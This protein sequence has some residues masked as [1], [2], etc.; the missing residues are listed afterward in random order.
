MHFHGT[1]AR[2]RLSRRDGAL[3]LFF[4]IGLEHEGGVIGVAA[5]HPRARAA[6]RD[7]LRRL[8]IAEVLRCKEGARRRHGVRTGRGARVC[9]AG[10]G[11]ADGRPRVERQDRAQQRRMLQ[12]IADRVRAAHRSAGAAHSAVWGWFAAR[13]RQARGTAGAERAS[14]QQQ[15]GGR[16]GEAQANCKLTGGGSAWSLSITDQVI[17]CTINNGQY[18]YRYIPAPVPDRY[19]ANPQSR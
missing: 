17:L 5:A 8:L 2:K 13:A 4:A 14:P 9:D 10:G 16:A 15:A 18:R 11:R 12:H 7:T 6:R 3:P 19:T 1:R